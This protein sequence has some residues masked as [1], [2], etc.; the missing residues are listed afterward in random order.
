M[1]I[2]QLGDQCHPHRGLST[3][4]MGL[5]S[6]AGLLKFAWTRNYVLAS[7]IAGL[8][9]AAAPVVF[10]LSQVPEAEDDGKIKLGGFVFVFLLISGLTVWGAS[11]QLVALFDAV[12]E[13]G[14][15][16]VVSAAVATLLRV[17]LGCAGAALAWY[18]GSSI[19][20]TIRSQIADS[21][22]APPLH[23]MTATTH[24]GQRYWRV[25]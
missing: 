18:I 17:V 20:A 4:L 10:N 19:P 1:G 21:A 5:P 2:R 3:A 23:A 16:G 11:I 14:D 13:L 7:A 25:L 6:A 9:A 12:G 22:P 8:L 15:R 24:P